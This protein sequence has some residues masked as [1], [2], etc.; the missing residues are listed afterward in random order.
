L[1]DTVGGSGADGDGFH[2]QFVNMVKDWKFKA[3]I[4]AALCD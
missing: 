2:G 1:V 3:K 4:V